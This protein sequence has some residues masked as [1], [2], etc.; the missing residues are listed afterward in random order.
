MSGARRDDQSLSRW[1]C[2]ELAGQLY[3]L[4]ISGVQEVLAD[5]SIEPVP[6]TTPLVLGVI[7]LRG[8]VVT[9]LD[10]RRHFGFPAVQDAQTRIIVVDHGSEALGL[11]VDRVADVRKLAEGAI[12]PAPAAGGGAAEAGI[13]GMVSRS[14]ELLTLLDPARL[15]AEL[16]LLV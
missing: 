16:P 6:G 10:L 11:C 4:P 15:L 3:G 5:I 13:R 1:V 2:F 12:K 7:N 14:G 9:V 8:N